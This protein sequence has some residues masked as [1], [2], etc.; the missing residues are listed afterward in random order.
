MKKA[1]KR[2]EI[3]LGENVLTITTKKTR[4]RTLETVIEIILHEYERKKPDELEKFMLILNDRYQV[5]RNGGQPQEIEPLDD[6]DFWKG[7]MEQDPQ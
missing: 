7:L 6:Y 4:I 5:V 2:F 3:H 1:E